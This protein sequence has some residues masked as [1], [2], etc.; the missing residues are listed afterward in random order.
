MAVM[1]AAASVVES[2]RIN[3]YYSLTTTAEPFTSPKTIGVN[4]GHNYGRR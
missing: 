1:L 3:A 4:A 2:Q